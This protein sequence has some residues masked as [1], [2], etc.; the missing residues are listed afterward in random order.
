MKKCSWDFTQALQIKGAVKGKSLSFIFIYVWTNLAKNVFPWAKICITDN[1]I[2]T[3]KTRI[4]CSS[5]VFS[6]H[7]EVKESCKREFITFT[8]GSLIITDAVNV[9]LKPIC[10]QDGLPKPRLENFA[11]HISVLFHAQLNNN[12]TQLKY[13]FN[14]K[15]WII[16]FIFF[17]KYSIHDK[18]KCLQYTN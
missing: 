5:L 14:T 8:M 6:S 11:S 2:K 17:L 4:S 9:G 12:T 3:N 7:S 15:R 16:P 13:N 18:L 10:P 1:K